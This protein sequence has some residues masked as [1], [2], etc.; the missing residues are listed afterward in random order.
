MSVRHAALWSALVLV[1]VLGAAL[2]VPRLVPEVPFF[3][4]HAIEISGAR[5]LD[6]TTVVRRLALPPDAH[7]LL[8]LEPVRAAAHAIPGVVAAT[9]ER[10]W[11]GTLRV[12]L[13]ESLPIAITPQEDRFVL[14]DERARVLPFA[15][16]RVD[17]SLPIASRDSMTAALLARM[18]RADPALYDR[19]E[20]ARPE[21]GDVVLQQGARE[22][23]L[24]GDAGEATMRAV[25]AVQAWL[26]ANG[27]AWQE[28]DA[29]FRGRVFVRRGS[30]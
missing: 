3:R 15:L 30:A 29:R 12:H 14:I 19:V 4:I 18:R 21:G 9:V 23:R 20:H 25:V 7:I 10:R 26:A 22:V 17:V 13:T 5:Y 11:P 24:R 16:S 1:V 2:A 28:L 6:D 27:T 8:P